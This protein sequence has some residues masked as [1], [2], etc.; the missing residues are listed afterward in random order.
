MAQVLSVPRPLSIIHEKRRNVL[1][2]YLVL[3]CRAGGGPITYKI[4]LNSV[5]G[6]NIIIQKP[7]WG[8]FQFSM[9]NVHEEHEQEDNKIYFLFYITCI[10]KKNKSAISWVQRTLKRKNESEN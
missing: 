7:W 8:S 6:S 5:K 3:Y 10:Y 4:Y 2:Y 9:E 1:N